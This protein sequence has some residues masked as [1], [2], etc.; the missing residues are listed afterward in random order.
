MAAVLPLPTV[1][2][3]VRLLSALRFFQKLNCHAGIQQDVDG[4]LVGGASLKPEFV[5]IVN[6]NLA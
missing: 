1:K 6:T 5:N 3:S 4:F 2:N